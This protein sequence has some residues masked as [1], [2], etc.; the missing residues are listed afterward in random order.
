M[1]MLGQHC[2][3]VTLF[4]YAH[5]VSQAHIARPASQPSRNFAAILP[6]QV[7]QDERAQ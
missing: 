7:T 2:S 3:I 4:Q 1:S 5:T 6:A